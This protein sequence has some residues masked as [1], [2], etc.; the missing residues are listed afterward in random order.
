ML[1]GS[2]VFLSGSGKRDE[3]FP[4]SA[5]RFTQR[6]LG[7]H[8]DRLAFGIGLV[9]G[10]TDF[11]TQPTARAIFRG[12]LDGE[13]HSGEFLELGIQG[14]KGRR[15][16]RKELGIV[17]LLADDC[18]RADERAFT[19]LDAQVG[20]PDRDLEGNIALFPAGGGGGEGAIHRQLA[21]GKT[22]AIV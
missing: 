10:G 2:N 6:R 14:L 3:E 4:V 16:F 19:A 12:N 11:N 7:S 17:H 13:L 15:S 9:L 21:D 5:F 1:V 20:F 22:I 8:V 18:M